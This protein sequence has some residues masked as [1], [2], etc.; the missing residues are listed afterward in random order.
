MTQE[1]LTDREYIS[2]LI[3]R[4]RKAQEQIANLTQEDVLN[5]ARSIGWLA[6]D[7]ADEWAHINFEETHMG[8]ELSKSTRTRARARGLMR[9]LLNTKTVGIIEEDHEK[10]LVKIA[11]PVGVIG[12]LVPITVPAGVVFIKAMNGLMGRNAL[13]YAP[14][15]RAQKTAHTVV[16]DLRAL[17]K[18]LGY[19]EDLLIC[20]DDIST[21]RTNELMRQCDLVVATGGAGMVKA[22]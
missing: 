13:V 22:A 3:Q 17:L 8:D 21:E 4:A 20:I 7:R 6:I 19:P 5:I 12:A 18:R 11:K 2:A 15:P 16:N 1:T 10:Q 9:D 14:H